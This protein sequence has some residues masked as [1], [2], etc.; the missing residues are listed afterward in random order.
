ISLTGQPHTV[1]SPAQPSRLVIEDLAH[2]PTTEREA[3]TYRLASEEALRPFNLSTGPVLRVKLLRLGE[4]EHVILLTMHHIVSDAWSLGI[5]VRELAALYQAFNSSAPSPLAELSI[6]YSDFALWQREW[7]Q[8]EVLERELAYW[9][10]QLG[11]ELPVLELPTDHPRPAIQS[12]QGAYLPIRIPT[13]VAQALR[14]LAQQPQCTLFMVLLA[15][16]Q[17][18]LFRLTSQEDVVVGTPIAGRNRA[19]IE[20]L[21]GFFI[22]T[23]VLR[24]NV[25]GNPSF[26]ELIGRVK[27]VALG[28][29]AHQD[30][31]FEKLVEE[32]HPERD[33]SRSPLFQ[34]MFSMQNVAADGAVETSGLRLSPVESK[35]ES[36]K[37][38]L[39][40]SLTDLGE[41]ITG[42]LE[43]NTDLFETATIERISERFLNLLR[44]VAADP[45]Q[46]VGH[47]ELLSAAE[48]E[49]LLVE[50]NDTAVEQPRELCIQESFER[51]AALTPD[52][53]AVVFGNEQ[54]TYAELN[55]RANHLGHHLR[56]LGVGAETLVGLCV[57]RSP[58]LLVGLLGI[59]KAGG[60][61]VPLDPNYP[62]ERLE[63]MLADADLSVVVTQ[64]Q[65]AT[66][67]SESQCVV[68][69]DD[70]AQPALAGENPALV[71]EPANL[72]YVIYTSGSSGR[73]KGVAI[74]H[75]ALVNH[76]QS[77][78]THYEL[79]ATDRVLQFASLSFD[80]ALEE[81]FPTWG[82]GG[83]VVM[84]TGAELTA[85][86]FWT[87]VR[88]HEISV[89]N[90][91]TWYWQEVME[92]LARREEPLPSSLRLM[93]IGSERGRGAQLA[94]WSRLLPDGVRLMH[95]YGPTEA[96][97]TATVSEVGNREWDSAES[98]PIGR[99][100]GNVEAYVLDQRQ[101]LVGVGIA[102]ELYLGG[103]GM[104]RG[105]LGRAA[106]TAE[107][108]VPDSYS[109]RAGARLYRTGDLA[110]WRADGELEFIGR[111]DEQVK[112]R[113][114]RIELGEIEAALLG[115]G[116]VRE[117]VVVAR[118]D[119][120]VGYVVAEADELNTAYVREYLIERL[121]SYMVPSALIQ[122]TELP[123]TPNGKV[124]RK[125][126]ALR[127]D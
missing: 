56:S 30:V 70:Y 73:P 45:D 49:Q 44:A 14:E 94:V 5:F 27:E 24:T 85:A 39:T 123:L 88:E 76:A 103:A 107:K 116:G 29:Y 10:K 84:R 31:P 82:S 21:I 69:M 8:G 118:E 90:L 108:F 125:A 67:M 105:Y 43:Y 53:V 12:Y 122:L 111:V 26:R 22:N 120:L 74:T 106:E 93:V 51:Q 47:V 7:L 91:V 66:L 60:A 65:F 104:G 9:R 54:L 83:C 127:E 61:Y 113:G 95:G 86:E 124:D 17:A 71:T 11:G 78:A 41:A 79:K 68:W 28:A 126:L 48:R 100:I 16:F 57:E 64:R 23:L 117:A 102:G 18:V 52:A 110:K 13:E 20:P 99:G 115:H 32:L 92:E 40:L 33:L 19:E 6:Q 80:V 50:W 62:A 46:R 2:L 55:R 35:R 75:A 112:V 3:E 58:E 109:G 89:V 87:L 15:A 34:V 121:P 114:Y 42:T 59:L 101:E 37:F 96:T 4:Q 119:R 1:V 25:S 63:Y 77:M 72:A 81:L 98:L 36:A 97:V 38:D